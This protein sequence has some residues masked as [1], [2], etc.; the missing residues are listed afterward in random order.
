MRFMDLD[1]ILTGAAGPSGPTVISSQVLQREL[2]PGL[3]KLT[4]THVQHDHLKDHKIKI[5]N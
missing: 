2:G 5:G 1:P 3:L 4:V